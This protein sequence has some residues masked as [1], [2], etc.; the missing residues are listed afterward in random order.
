MTRRPIGQ[1][2]LAHTGELMAIP[3]VV[4]TGEGTSAGRPAL[5]VLVERR[6]PAIVARIPREI[7]GYP[8]EVRETGKVRAL[9]GR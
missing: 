8:V 2:L 5:V 4:G 6:T 7:E 9:Q 3:G 1:V